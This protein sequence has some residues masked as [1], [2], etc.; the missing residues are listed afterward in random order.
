[1]L[2]NEFSGKW[3]A[4]ARYATLVP[5]NPIVLAGQDQ[6]QNTALT[7]RYVNY[8]IVGAKYSQGAH[9]LV[10]NLLRRD[11]QASPAG[12]RRRHQLAYTY[13]LSKRTELQAFFDRDGVDSS[14]ANAAIRSVGAGIRH[15]F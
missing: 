13:A 14:K 7:R 1:M 5:S 12:V 11:V 9:A 4:G 6:Y 2:A 3:Q 10:L 8:W 15:D